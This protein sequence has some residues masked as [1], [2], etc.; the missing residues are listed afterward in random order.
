MNKLRILR[1]RDYSVLPEWAQCNHMS[2]SE[3]ASRIRAGEKIKGTM[4]TEAEIRAERRSCAAGF[5]DGGSEPRNMGC[6]R[7]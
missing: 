5:E 2:F 3:G 7:G 6:L 1:W 4:R